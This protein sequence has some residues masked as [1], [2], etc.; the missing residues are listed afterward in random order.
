MGRIVVPGEGG[1]GTPP[2][3]MGF[4]PGSW[5]EGDISRL[6]VSSGG[7]GGMTSAIFLDRRNG[8]R[9]WRSWINGTNGQQ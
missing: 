4:G 5:A 8:W 9:E 2:L 1:R 6:W 3:G 7:G